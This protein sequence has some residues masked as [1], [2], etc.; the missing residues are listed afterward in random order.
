MADDDSPVRQGRE[1]ARAA[2]LKAQLKANMGRRKAQ[3]RA[4]MAEDAARPTPTETM[5]PTDD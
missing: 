5:D 1:T 4:R 3:T 2:R